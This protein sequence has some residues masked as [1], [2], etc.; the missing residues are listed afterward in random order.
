MALNKLPTKMYPGFALSM[1][2]RAVKEYFA[3]RCNAT[4]LR[5]LAEH[6]AQEGVM[7]CMY[8]GAENPTRW[9]HLHPVSQG[10]DSTPGN[11][12]P[13]CGRCDDSKQDKTIEQWAASKS[14]YRPPKTRVSAI[15]ERIARYRALFVYA[16]KDFD[17]KLN[18]KQR[19]IYRRFRLRLDALRDQ[20]RRDGL[21]K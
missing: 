16:P 7:R 1:L 18:R 9:D 8:C 20:F 19:A 5:G 12:V 13:A 17:Q 21:I 14:K 11:L 3:A 10:G 15:V 4:D 2:D 6:F